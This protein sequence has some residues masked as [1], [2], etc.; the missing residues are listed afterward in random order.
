[1]KEMKENSKKFININE[2]L[3]TLNI[4][5]LYLNIERSVVINKINLLV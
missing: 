1:M 4:I 5:L 3:L 2:L